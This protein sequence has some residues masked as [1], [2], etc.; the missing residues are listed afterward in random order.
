MHYIALEYTSFGLDIRNDI[1]FI[2]LITLLASNSRLH[3]NEICLSFQCP[4]S[5]I[6]MHILDD[7]YVIYFLSFVSSMPLNTI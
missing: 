7:N 4:K 3:I 1:N 5:N 2:G 6:V